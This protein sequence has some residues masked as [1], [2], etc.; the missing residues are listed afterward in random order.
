MKCNDEPTTMTRI[1]FIDK[2]YLGTNDYTYS[3]FGH[4]KDK[5]LM[6]FV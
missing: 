2:V 6:W 3:I 5:R 4:K 1:F